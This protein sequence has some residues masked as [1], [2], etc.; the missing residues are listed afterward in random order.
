[1]TATSAPAS[2]SG[3]AFY[4]CLLGLLFG[5]VVSLA[6]AL[7]FTRWLGWLNAETE[8]YFLAAVW[9]LSVGVA[10]FIACRRQGDSPWTV[11]AFVAGLALLVVLPDPDPQAPQVFTEAIAQLFRNPQV[12]SA[13][14]IRFA[15]TAPAAISGTIAYLY[16][17]RNPASTTGE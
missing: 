17:R 6:G 13:E 1:M 14:F 2:P 11:T 15:L 8:R 10:S 9:P 16:R 3:S 4:G 7:L 12:N 5:C